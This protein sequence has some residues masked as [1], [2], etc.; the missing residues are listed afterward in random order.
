MLLH[1]KG[2]RRS[3]RKEALVLPIWHN[4]RFDL[5][6]IS[7][8]WKAKLRGLP[9]YGVVSAGKPGNVPSVFSHMTR[10]RYASILRFDERKAEGGIEKNLVGNLYPKADSY[11][12]PGLNCLPRTSLPVENLNP[13]DRTSLILFFLHHL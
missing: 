8:R 3:H 4:G 10:I 7:L 5:H 13:L 1:L 11:R 9:L 12:A 2:S 6:G